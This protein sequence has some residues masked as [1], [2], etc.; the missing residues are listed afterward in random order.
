VRAVLGLGIALMTLACDAESEV[1]PRTPVN[2]QLTEPTCVAAPA[3][4]D[5]FPAA[6]AASQV[7]DPYWVERPMSI[8]LGAIGDGPLNQEPIPHR[9]AE[10][11]KPFPCDWTNTCDL[12]P[13]V[14]AP[15]AL[16][17]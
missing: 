15:W 17:R 9:L 12:R 3:L 8:N 6:F 1:A 5:G 16:P 14:L 4:Q 7:D 10:W 2:A 11:E 13:V